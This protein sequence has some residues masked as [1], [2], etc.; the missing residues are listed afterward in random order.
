MARFKEKPQ[1]NLKVILIKLKPPTKN[2]VTTVDGLKLTKNI[3]ATVSILYTQHQHNIKLTMV[4]GSI[5]KWAAAFFNESV[6]LRSSGP[7][8]SR[9]NGSRQYGICV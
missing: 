8:V 4:T 6:P 2:L 5:R 1:S 7:K 9:V 3:F